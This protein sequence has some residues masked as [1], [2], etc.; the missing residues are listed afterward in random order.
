ML[1]HRFGGQV[2]RLLQRRQQVAII[3]RQLSTIAK[4]R[5]MMDGML[6]V[7]VS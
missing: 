3:R 1:Q 2:S 6:V 7:E 4:E 5:K